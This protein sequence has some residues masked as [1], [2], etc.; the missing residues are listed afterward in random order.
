MTHEELKRE[1]REIKRTL[2]SLEEALN[3]IVLSTD[4]KKLLT[5]RQVAE[6]INR[7]YSQTQKLVN[8]GEL[9]YTMVGKRKMFT[10]KN[11]SDY[12]QGK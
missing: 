6:K 5:L 1:L 12:L 3:F 8:N 10:Q 2:R 9:G 7:S 11:I 4:Q